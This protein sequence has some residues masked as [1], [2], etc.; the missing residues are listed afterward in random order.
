MDGRTFT[1]FYIL[2][3]ALHCIGQPKKTKF[4][5]LWLQIPNFWEN[6]RG[7]SKSGNYLSKN[8]NLLPPQL[9]NARR[10]SILPLPLRISWPIAAV[11]DEDEVTERLVAHTQQC[12]HRRVQDVQVGLD[13]PPVPEVGLP[14]RTREVQ[15]ERLFRWRHVVVVLETFDVRLTQRAP[16]WTNTDNQ[17]I[18]SG[19]WRPKTP[20]SPATQNASQKS[21]GDKNKELKGGGAKFTFL[22]Q[23][24]II[25][26]MWR[27]F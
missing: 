9:F 25:A 14:P 24:K 23:G 10:R 11:V 2:S 26:A 21:L 4:Q 15:T 19:Q 18:T 20:P 16:N 7:K 17:Q 6:R 1:W 22:F 5:N 27:D 12:L 3:N 8:C 13:R